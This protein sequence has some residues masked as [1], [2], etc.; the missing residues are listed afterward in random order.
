MSRASLHYNKYIKDNN[1]TS[2]Y[3]EIK[4]GDKVKLLFLKTPNKFGTDVIAFNSDNFIS[5]IKDYVDYNVQFT[6][7]FLNPLNNIVR[8]LGYDMTSNVNVIDEW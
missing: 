8:V 2:M 6:K 1:L 3:T 4:S 7:G 5:E